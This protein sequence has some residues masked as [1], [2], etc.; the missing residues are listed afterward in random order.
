[1]KSSLALQSICKSISA[2]QF[3]PNY[4]NKKIILTHGRQCISIG[5][6]ALTVIS[7]IWT[8]HWRYHLKIIFFSNY[9]KTNY[10]NKMNCHE[11]TKNDI[12]WSNQF[13]KNL[14]NIA[15]R[16]LDYSYT[17]IFIGEMVLPASGK[18][19]SRPSQIVLGFSH[20][21]KAWHLIPS[22]REVC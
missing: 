14:N 20:D 1:M 7:V 10:W 8:L 3:S 21:G 9:W 12:S 4:V 6:V 19:V 18:F 13:K 5:W 22:T 2:L 15:I 17:L 11:I 16:S